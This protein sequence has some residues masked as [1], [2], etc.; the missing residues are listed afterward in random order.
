MV[1]IF[2][3]LTPL[4]SAVFT[5]STIHRTMATV[6]DTTANLVPL[7][8]Q[9]SG[10]TT[11]FMLSAYETLW[12]GQELPGFTTMTG[13]VLP[14][15]SR[16]PQ[17]SFLVNET[18]TA[19]TS[20]YSTSLACEP[21]AI[22]TSEGCFT[23]DNRRGCHTEPVE[24]LGG[25]SL[26]EALYIGYADGPNI[27]W[28]LSY[29]GCAAN[30]SHEDLAIWAEGPVE[31][32]TS[33]ITALFCRPSYFVQT[34]NATVTIPNM[35]V[36][37]ITPL[38]SPVQLTE[39]VFNIPNFE[40]VIGTGALPVT[41][42]ADIAQTA[43]LEQWPRISHMRLG[44]PTTNMVGFAIGEKKLRP[45]DY[46][47]ADILASSFESA[48][49]LLFALAFSSLLTTNLSN[50]ETRTGIIEGTMNTVMIIRT[51]AILVEASLG[52]LAALA[53][54]LLYFSSSRRSQLWYDPASIK[55][56][57]MVV[58]Q[59]SLIL[60]S[61]SNSDDTSDTAHTV[62]SGQHRYRL[63]SGRCLP[64]LQNPASVENSVEAMK[65]PRDISPPNEENPKAV[66]PV[67]LSTPV[68]VAM[69]TILFLVTT[70]LVVL[71]VMI[72]KLNGT[73]YQVIYIIDN[74]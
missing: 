4:Q 51:L 41:P 8:D 23:F 48:H 27:D 53:A 39:E 62:E 20:F 16:E 50:S 22:G 30:A 66:R 58:T 7:S 32:E 28:S 57:I 13:A 70:L 63:R 31:G 25:D 3:A 72:T 67:E 34:V 52:L 5:T 29:L 59:S 21:A 36:S 44:W 74:E 10:L 71:Q 42:R 73:S 54:A 55:R 35:I 11:G 40:Y 19:A 2:G 17:H 12:L 49:K 61:F 43:I 24:F 9:A 38:G 26:F 33:N 69:L 37:S 65:V 68:G 56:T 46:M 60:K 14:F 15:A 64:E 18:L 6:I 45:A 1:A 47:D